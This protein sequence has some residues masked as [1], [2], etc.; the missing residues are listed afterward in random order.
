MVYS[1]TE[2]IRAHQDVTQRRYNHSYDRYVR[3][4]IC[5][6]CGTAIGE[7]DCYP[8]FPNL[9][10]QFQDEK[11]NY[12]FCPYCGHKFKKEKQKGDDICVKIFQTHSHGT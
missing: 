11:D 12:K 7:Q 6:K 3:E 5:S 8:D 9:G 4:A 1:S 10:F 2:F